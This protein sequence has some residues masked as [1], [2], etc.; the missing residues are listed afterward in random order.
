LVDPKQLPKE[1]AAAEWPPQKLIDAKAERPTSNTKRRSQY[2]LEDTRL[3]K[4]VVSAV[5]ASPFRTTKKTKLGSQTPSTSLSF[6]KIIL[7]SI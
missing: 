4:P 3:N 1:L 2:V 5:N 6:V 7:N